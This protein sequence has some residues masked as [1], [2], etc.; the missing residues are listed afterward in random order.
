[1]LSLFKTKK[2][3]DLS[4]LG[5]DMHSHL[6]PGIDDGCPDAETSIACMNGLRE[7]GLH[8]FIMT[9]HIY[10][11]IHPNSPDTIRPAYQGLRQAMDEAGM[12]DV[13]TAAAAEYMIDDNF[14]SY[15]APGGEM[16][17]LPERQVLIE[18]SYQFER[19][20]LS[21]HI[22]QLQLHEYQP[23]LAHP[24]RYNYYHSSP[25]TYTR[26]KE[27][28]CRFQLNLLSLSGYYGEPVRK[29]AQH[30]V[31]EKM[32]DYIGTDLH[33]LRHLKAVQNFVR[34]TDLHKMLHG[35]NIRNNGLV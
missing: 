5:A 21:E 31:K 18:M 6:I 30:L 10:S 20:D 11:E 22:F 35:N 32:I 24:E 3:Y 12:Q 26:L 1:M 33:H 23:I 34:T 9:P 16:M 2:T 28:G 19:Q 13:R 29:M 27:R 17:V 8:T 25:Q 14:A 7:L 4:W 15:Y